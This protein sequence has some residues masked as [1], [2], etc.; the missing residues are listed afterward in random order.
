MVFQK[1]ICSL[2]CAKQQGF[3]V[4]VLIKE[5]A[6]SKAEELLINKSIESEEC[7]LKVSFNWVLI[8]RALCSRRSYSHIS[9]ISK[10]F[11]EKKTRYGKHFYVHPFECHY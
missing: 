6:F 4:N 10:A 2:L 3:S 1:N 9:K 5:I 11:Q 8:F 7:Q